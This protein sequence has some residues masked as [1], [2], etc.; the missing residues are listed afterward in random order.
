MSD[1]AFR[2]PQTI[3]IG[4]FNITE[5]HDGYFDLP[6]SYLI[7]DAG[8]PA[9]DT[10][11]LRI[12]VNAFLVRRDG[13]NYL[14]DTGCGPKLAP[15]AG[16]VVS[17]LQKLGVS[18]SDIDG[19]ILTHIHPDHVMGLV[20]AEGAAVYV[21]ASVHVHRNE[22]DY[23]MDDESRQAAAEDIRYQYV[24]AKEALAPYKDRIKVFTDG[25]PF[26][27]GISAVSLF[28]HTP[29][30][31]GIVFD[32]GAAD[33]LLI[34]G[35][36]VHAI[37]IQSVHPSVAFI[38]DMDI[39][40]AK[41]AR[42]KAFDLAATDGLIVSGMHVRFPGFGRIEREGPASYRWAAVG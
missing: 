6:N 1:D 28:G 30:H 23:W 35:D 24:W 20:D 41:A 42:L 37:D 3:E 2:N 8:K 40:A 39:Q 14:V 13:R 27:P 22:L 38:A 34:W 31:C 12:D 25:E 9:V 5:L 33:R 17:H 19:I 18:P 10:E 7:D 11:N 21:N 15:T 36:C 4:A 16:R 26:L 29:A 32:G